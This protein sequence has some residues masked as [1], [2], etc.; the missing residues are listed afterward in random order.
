MS[1]GL[2]LGTSCRPEEPKSPRPK[3]RFL[4]LVTAKRTPQRA[5]PV[6]QARRMSPPM[7]LGKVGD[8]RLLGPSNALY[9]T[10]T[11]VYTASR[12]LRRPHSLLAEAYP[13]R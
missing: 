1:I 4:S 3:G 13:H 10:Y 7:G 9:T 6:A 11:V 8:P 5:P 2:G 12:L